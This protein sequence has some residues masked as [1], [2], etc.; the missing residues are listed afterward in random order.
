SE[1]TTVFERPSACATDSG[2]PASRA[3]FTT[4]RSTTG[5]G[6]GLTTACLGSGA[7]CVTGLVVAVAAFLVTPEPNVWCWIT[8]G[9][10]VSLLPCAPSNRSPPNTMTVK[11]SPQIAAILTGGESVSVTGFLSALEQ[12]T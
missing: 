11:T 1:T 9:A 10:A 8:C 3:A 7:L 12:G 2:R 4:A 6:L 5:W